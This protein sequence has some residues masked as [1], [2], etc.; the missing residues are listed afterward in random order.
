MPIATHGFAFPGQGLARQW[1]GYCFDPRILMAWHAVGGVVPRTTHTR[2]CSTVSS[3]TP[4]LGKC[5]LV[6]SG[7]GSTEH[8]TVSYSTDND[9][10]RLLGSAKP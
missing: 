9:A 6:G 10:L 2:M 4:Q 3:Q 5:W 1:D 7:P 8:L